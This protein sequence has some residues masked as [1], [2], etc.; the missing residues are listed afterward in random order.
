VRRRIQHGLAKNGEFTLF[1]FEHRFD[2][3]KKRGV[4]KFLN[5]RRQ[6]NGGKK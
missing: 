4:L 6:I 3:L 1:T 5:L 2:I